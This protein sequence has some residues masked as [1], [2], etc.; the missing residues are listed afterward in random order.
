MSPCPPER[1][2]PAFVRPASPA[3]SAALSIRRCPLSPAFHLRSRPAAAQPLFGSPFRLP[4]RTPEE[5]LQGICRAAPNALVEM[6]RLE[7]STP[8]CKAGALPS[9][10]H[11]HVHSRLTPHRFE[12]PASLFQETAGTAFAVPAPG[13]SK[14]NSAQASFD[15][16]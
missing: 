6:N 15:S 2:S 13:P 10:L 16:F 14:L 9:E 7:L 12:F 5:F 8:A 11:P 4:A 3:L 1:R